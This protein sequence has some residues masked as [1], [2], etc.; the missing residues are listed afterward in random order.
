[1]SKRILIAICAALAVFGGARLATAQTSTS[2]DSLADAARKAQAEKKAQP[3]P[4][5]V[6]TDDNIGAISGNVSVVGAAPG[7]APAASSGDE[8][9]GKEKAPAEK[10]DE[11][12]FRNK[13]AQLRE[14]LELD[15]KELDVLQ[16]E[17]GLKQQQYYSDPN[18][19]MKE[20]Y[21]RKDLDDTKNEIDQKNQDIAADQQAITDLEDE[22]RRSGGDPG[23][24]REDAPPASSSS[25]PG[26]A[27]PESGAPPSDVTPSD[28]SAPAPTTAPAPAAPSD[29]APA[30]ATDSGA[31]APPSA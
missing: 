1:M 12:Y 28:N 30:P 5:I 6:Y 2:Q 4:A 9:G 14:K 23:W 26:E 8:S 18:T 27:A 21:S 19:A 22:L 24:E 20:E 25:T 16:R 31:A 7:T 29:Q 17:F 11:A 10:K 13:F 15:Q 3:K